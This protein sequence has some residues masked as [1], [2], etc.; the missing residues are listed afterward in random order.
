MSLLNRLYRGN[1]DFNFP[2][3]YKRA[4]IVSGFLV[5]VSVISFFANGLNLAIDFE[6]GTVWEVP[7]KTFETDAAEGVLGQFSKGAG[8]KIQEVTNADGQRIVRIQA[9]VKDVDEAA[10]VTDALAKAA[11][12]EVESIDSS[13]VGPSWGDAVTKQAVKALLVF[14]ILVFAYISFTLEW[15]MAVGAIVALLHDIVLTVGVYSVFGFEVTP[16]TVVSFLTILGFSL[17]DTIVVYDRVQENGDRFGRTGSY[18]YET[19]MRRSLNQVLMRSINTTLVALMP[20]VAILVIGAGIYGQE[21]LKDFGIALF[22]GMVSGVFS[23]LAVAAPTVVALKEREPQYR[24]IRQRIIDRGGDANDSTWVDRTE[25]KTSGLRPMQ[26][27]GATA[28]DRLTTRAAQYDR[29]HPPRPRKG[30]KR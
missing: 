7:S 30:S 22:V 28:T 10:K 8:S 3:F 5:L 16:A 23:S 4:L 12:V 1:T 9:E 18:T 14:L 26:T 17:Y 11:N 29:N 21:T 6:G 15:R 27:S 20:V 19:I 2:K 24:R 25:R 13:F